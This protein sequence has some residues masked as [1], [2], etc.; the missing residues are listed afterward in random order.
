MVTLQERKTRDINQVKCIKDDAN[1]FLVKD[2]EIKNKLRE[3][4]NKLFN[5][6][7]EETVTELDDLIDDTNRRFVQRIQ[8]SDVKE[9]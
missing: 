1:R 6:E 9:A 5:E 3:Y 7:S 8:E 4:F 2:D